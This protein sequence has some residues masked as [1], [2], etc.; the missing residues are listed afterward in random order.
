MTPCISSVD[1]AVEDI[2]IEDGVEI[3][4]FPQEWKNGIGELK[5]LAFLYATK[6]EEA[7]IIW[8]KEDALCSLII[9]ELKK[10]KKPFHEVV[11]SSKNK[12]A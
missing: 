5:Q 2:T 4:A 9:E 12:K 6:A 1:W 7:L 10:Q 11:F 8:D 3:G